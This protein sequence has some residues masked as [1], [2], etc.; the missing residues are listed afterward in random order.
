MQVQGLLRIFKALL[1]PVQAHALSARPAWVPL[2][3]PEGVLRAES[4]TSSTGLH[5]L[6]A[7]C[8]DSLSYRLSTNH[9][10][11]S[12]RLN[13]VIHHLGMKTHLR[14]SHHCMKT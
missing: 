4:T 5:D 14:P 2:S 12:S 9:Y 7:C 11:I 1:K 8:L 6:Q 10:E 13:F 3:P